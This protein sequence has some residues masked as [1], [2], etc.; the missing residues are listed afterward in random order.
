MQNRVK[1]LSFI[2]HWIVNQLPWKLASSREFSYAW[3]SS[4]VC[5]TL[6]VS[7]VGCGSLSSL[8]LT[9]SEDES[10]SVAPLPALE[11]VSRTNWRLQN[12]TGKGLFFLSRDVSGVLASNFIFI[13]HRL[14]CSIS[15][16]LAEGHLISSRTIKV[17]NMPRLERGAILPSIQLAFQRWICYGACVLKHVNGKKKNCIHMLKDHWSWEVYLFLY[18]CKSLQNN[19]TVRLFSP[20]FFT[21]VPTAKNI[22]CPQQFVY[23]GHLF[24]TTKS[25]VLHKNSLKWFQSLC[26]KLLHKV[27]Y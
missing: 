16:E 21:L 19:C 4:Y 20:H 14:F 11:Q 12:A 1:C 17:A 2:R 22:H 18:Y 15:T 27:L 25:P 10:T 24:Y 5:Y 3:F 13:D 6:C 7:G 26:A 23:E 8:L 9:G